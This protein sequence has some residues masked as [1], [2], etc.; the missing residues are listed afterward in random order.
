MSRLHD[1]PQLVQAVQACYVDEQYHPEGSR[2]LTR[3]PVEKGGPFV[4]VTPDTPSTV[5]VPPQYVVAAP[6]PP[7]SL[8]VPARG[9]QPPLPWA[10]QPAA[11]AGSAAALA[12]GSTPRPDIPD[13]LAAMFD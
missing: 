1:Q 6:I 11:L 4:L 7:A 8:A 12:A 5:T 3:H 9:L 10:P 2:F 13:D